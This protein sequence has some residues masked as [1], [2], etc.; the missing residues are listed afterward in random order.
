MLL[1]FIDIAKNEQ[2][3]QI[4]TGIGSARTFQQGRSR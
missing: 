3:K 1:E 4:A 2:V